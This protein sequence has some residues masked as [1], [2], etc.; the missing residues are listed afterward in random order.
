MKLVKLL[1]AEQLADV[2]E[3]VLWEV[4]TRKVHLVPT[5]EAAE[6]RCTC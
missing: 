1:F 4:A 2:P 6:E 5:H 3:P